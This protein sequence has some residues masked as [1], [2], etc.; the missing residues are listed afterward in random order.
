MADKICCGICARNITEKQKHLKCKICKQLVHLKCNKFDIADYN[1]FKSQEITNKNFFCMKCIGENIAFSNLN[2]NEYCISVTKGINT[3]LNRENEI[4][5]TPTPAQQVLF[6]RLNSSINQISY[7]LNEDDDATAPLDCKY[8]NLE[9]FINAKFSPSKSFSIFHL[10]IHSI[11][12]HI[13][14]FRILLELIEFKFDVI[15]ITE[16]KL[17]DGVLPNIDINIDGYKTPINT[18]TKANKG[19]VL[20][21]VSDELNP[22]P[23]NDLKIYKNKLL[24][25]AFIELINPRKSN[26]II[27]VIYRHPSM[28]QNE[29]NDDYLKPLLDKISNEK[30]KNVYIAG[31]FNFDLLNSSTHD[32]TSNFFNL[33]TSNYLLPLITLPTR[34]N[35][36]NDTLIDNIFTNQYHPDVVTG[37]ITTGLSDH[38]PSFMIIPKTNQNHLPKKHNI[39]T[40]NTKTF[41][42]EN[43]FLDLLEIDWD[44]TIAIERNDVDISFENYMHAINNL[45]D[46]YMPLKKISKKQYKRKFKPWITNGILQSIKRKN[47]LFSKYVKSKN[48]DLK[49]ALHDDYKVLKNRIILITR[50]S[51]RNF[52]QNYFSENSNNLRTIWKGIKEVI[53]I[54]TKNLDHPSCLQENNKTITDPTLVAE[55][56]NNYFSSVADSILSKRKYHGHKMFSDYLK[57]PNHTQFNMTLTDCDEICTIIT[58]LNSN[59]SS[60]PNSIPTEI[61]KLMKHEISHPLSIIFNLS[62]SSGA[63]PKMLRLSKVIPIFKKGSRLLSCNYRPISLLSNINKILE[64]LVFYRLYKFLDLHNC[65]YSHQYGFREKHSTN[66]ALI[67]ITEKIRESLDNNKKICGIFVDLQKAFDTVNHN[68]LLKKLDYYGVRG[69][70][71]DWF[72]SYLFERKQYV[73]VLGF[74]SAFKIIKHGVPQGS[75]LGPLLFL[76]YIND[77]NICIQNSTVYHFADDTNLLNIQDDYKKLQKSINQDLKNLYMWLLANKISLNCSKTELIFFKKQATKIPTNIKIKINGTRLLPTN[78]IKYLGILLDET[79]SGNYH[80]K[81]LIKKLNRANGML[82]KARYYVPTSELISIYYA[83]FSSVMLYG[84]QIWGQTFSSSIEKIFKLQ[85]NAVR[86]ITFSE[87]RAHTDPLFKELNI[88]K[89]RD[90]ITLQNCLLVHDYLHKNLPANF[91]N[92]FIAI[93]DLYHIKTK[94]SNSGLLFKPF[95]KTTRY[96]LNSIKHRSISSWNYYSKHLKNTDLFIVLRKDF[97]KLITDDFISSYT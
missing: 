64:K 33:M 35:S 22:K 12:L 72:R 88:L 93:K 63:H 92:Y 20:L 32:E 85:K 49:N 61:L 83:I 1:Y 39:Y 15:A 34:I 62:F 86:L 11:Q 80:C 54:K 84:S 53:N 77:L 47:A 76:I 70:A 6:D 69:P 56:F 58:E 10:N 44:K 96:G 28:D 87:F 67:H 65:L 82:A 21:Y 91:E 71:N 3:S 9:E 24:E 25:S 27:G 29:F 19:G 23:R 30:N 14:E 79:L 17:I 52:Y 38:L 89:I 73:S 26:D 7:D 46:K 43:F 95:V 42:R 78:H 45:I 51:K 16:S 75:V 50:E 37:N 36:I 74:N 66:H 31:D 4:Q 41:D 57:T 59:K 8:Y 94:N 5:F 97:K 13:E 18:P 2:N 55:T 48:L 60:G 40:R 90:S 81:E 68:I